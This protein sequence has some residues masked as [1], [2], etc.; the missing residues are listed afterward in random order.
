MPLVAIGILALVSA[1]GFVAYCLG[2]SRPEH[3]IVPPGAWDEPHRPED[4]P[5]AACSCHT[6]GGA[7]EPKRPELTLRAP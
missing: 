7:P 3:E 1:V 6:V 5:D 4:C 2:F